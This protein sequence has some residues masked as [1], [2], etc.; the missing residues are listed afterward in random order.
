MCLVLLAYRACPGYR[1]VL[2]A[3]RDEFHE[4]PTAPARWWDDPPILAGRDLRAGGTWLAVDRLGRL[5]AVTNYRDPS[6]ANPHAAS[7]GALPVDFLASDDEAG[8]RA[9]L[10]R[11]AERYNGFNLL[12]LGAAGLSFLSNRSSSRPALPPGLYGL[13]NG[14]LDTPWPKVRRGRTLLEAEIA[15]GAVD[16]D[17]L[18]DLL[19]D[20]HQ[21]DDQHL[22][23]TGVGRTWERLL[24]PMFIV[25][26]RY[27]TRCSSVVLVADSGVVEFAERRFD[28]DGSSVGEVRERFQAA[29]RPAG[30]QKP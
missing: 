19:H 13:S 14:S 27:G 30:M 8:F 2:A 22:P 18:L 5:A 26:E 29:L 9:A 17:R 4:R 16:S 6:V 25:G 24:A 7:R 21:P 20:R 15:A 28:A 1:L 11:R 3:N 23:D 12:T 10:D